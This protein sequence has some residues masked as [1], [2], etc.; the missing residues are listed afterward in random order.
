MRG[1]SCL[2][3]C[4]G[5]CVGWRLWVLG[6]GMI[7]SFVCYEIDGRCHDAYAGGRSSVLSPR[8]QGEVSV[9]QP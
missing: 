3:S 6:G 7:G 9:L 1:C 2:F 8:C 5:L 4:L